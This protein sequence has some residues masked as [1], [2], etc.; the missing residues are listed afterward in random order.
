MV[1]EPKMNADDPDAFAC[2]RCGRAYSTSTFNCQCGYMECG[3]G[4]RTGGDMRGQCTPCL[5]EFLDLYD[6]V[7]ALMRS[8]VEVPFSIQKEWIHVIKAMGKITRKTDM[9]TDE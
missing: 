5:H 2:R 4:W 7:D 6:A 1:D 3:H 8:K 9:G